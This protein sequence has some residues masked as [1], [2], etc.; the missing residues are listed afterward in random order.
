MTIPPA[1]LGE[2]SEAGV[3]LLLE[4][5]QKELARYEHPLFQFSTEDR[6][7]SAL[8]AIDLREGLGLEHHYE[9]NLH[10]REI[11]SPQF[12]W[13]FK[14]SSTI[15]CTILLSRC[16]TGILKCASSALAANLA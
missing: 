6:R 14:S 16:L 8:L 9:I 7:A 5:V 3:H 13:S 4:K 1:S 11:V 2:P 15:A 10:E 12:P